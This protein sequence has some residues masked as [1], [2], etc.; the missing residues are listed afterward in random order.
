ME[1]NMKNFNTILAVGAVAAV[2]GAA[3]AALVAGWDFQT[4]TNGGTAASSASAPSSY[5]ANFGAGSLYLDGTQGSGTWTALNGYSGT[6]LNTAG[7]SFAT[8]TAS[9]SALG[10][11]N[12]TQNGKSMV[13]RLSMSGL[14][15][16]SLSFAAARSKSGSGLIGY[17][18]IDISYSANS[19]GSTPTAWTSVTSVSISAAA[20]SG[21]FEVFD[22]GDS[23][24]AADQQDFVFVRMTLSGATNSSG[25]FRLDNVQFNATPVPAPGAMALLGVAGL[26]GARRRR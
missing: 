19:S 11:A 4:T 20:A 21:A 12:G 8:S 22:L 2:C 13:F 14:S 15:D 23:F 25:T 17:S 24:A 7:T 1:P 18:G 9:P 6:N 16:L 5:T 26:L 10:I 3:E